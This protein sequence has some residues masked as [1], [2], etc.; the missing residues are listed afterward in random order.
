MKQ[1]RAVR[2]SS[3]LLPNIE[4]GGRVARFMNAVPQVILSSF[5]AQVNWDPSPEAST[6]G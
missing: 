6:R 1:G 3:R 5:A 2:H 4:H